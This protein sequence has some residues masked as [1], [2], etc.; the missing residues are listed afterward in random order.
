MKGMCP[1]TCPSDYF[2]QSADKA[3]P[4]AVLRKQ[5]GKSVQAC[6]TSLVKTPMHTE[7]HT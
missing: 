6:A 1:L 5:C 4:C 7:V 2:G 3:R